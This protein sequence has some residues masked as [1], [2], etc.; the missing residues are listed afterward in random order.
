MMKDLELGVF[1]T[2]RRMADGTL[3]TLFSPFLRTTTDCMQVVCARTLQQDGGCP[4]CTVFIDFILNFRM[5]VQFMLN[6]S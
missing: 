6:A 2:Q 5:T 3:H 1:F 4:N